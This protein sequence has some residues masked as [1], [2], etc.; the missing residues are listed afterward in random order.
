MVPAVPQSSTLRVCSKGLLGYCGSLN[1][2]G[3]KGE[4]RRERE[5][6]LISDWDSVIFEFLFV[7][8]LDTELFMPPLL[9]TESSGQVEERC[10]HIPCGFGGQRQAQLGPFLCNQKQE[11]E[12]T[13]AQ[14]ESQVTADVPWKSDTSNSAV[15]SHL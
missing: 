4:R 9:N 12:V 13:I 10:Q 8:V 15:V 6:D 5:S 14:A 2:Q 1:K 3:M 7:D 11:L